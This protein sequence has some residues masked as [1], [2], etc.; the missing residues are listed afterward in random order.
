LIENGIKTNFYL[1]EYKNQTNIN[2]FSN[3]LKSKES[4]LFG[5]NVTTDYLLRPGKYDIKV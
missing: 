2:S 4:F 1:E 5:A 3:V